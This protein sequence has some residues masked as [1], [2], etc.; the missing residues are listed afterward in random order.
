SRAF[1][2]PRKAVLPSCFLSVLFLFAPVLLVLILS[3]PVRLVERAHCSVQRIVAELAA[4]KHARDLAH[5]LV[6]AFCG[7]RAAALMRCDDER[8]A[9]AEQLL[10]SS[11]ER[12]SYALYNHHVPRLAR[13]QLIVLYRARGHTSF[14]SELC[15]R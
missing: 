9:A 6:Y 13:P 12:V 11:A 7:S 1:R 14:H 10:R 5:Q 8:F 2:R 4:R 3:Y 15:L